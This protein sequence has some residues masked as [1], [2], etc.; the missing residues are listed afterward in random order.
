[1]ARLRRFAEHAVSQIVQEKRSPFAQI[2]ELSV[3]LVSDARMAALHRDYLGS[4][5]STD[6]ITFAHGEI[7]VSV[8]AA[9]KQASEF[10]STFLEEI[11]LYLV[12]GLLH[13]AGYDDR[14][15]QQGRQMER[16]Q[17]RLLKQTRLQLA[18]DRN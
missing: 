5:E 18:K 10:N 4:F 3:V 12:H 7:F 13:L 15:P 17:D 8:E 11:E 2:A 1:M 9:E 16:A 14:K 6:V